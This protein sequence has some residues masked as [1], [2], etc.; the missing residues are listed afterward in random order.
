MCKQL[1]KKVL[2]RETRKEEGVKWEQG[3]SQ[4]AMASQAQTC[5]GWP[6]YALGRAQSLSYTTELAA[7]TFH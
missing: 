6:A 2:P 3:E 1:V 5:R 4:A 7:L